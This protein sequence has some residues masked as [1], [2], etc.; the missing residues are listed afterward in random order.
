MRHLQ[1]A[2]EVLNTPPIVPTADRLL[3]YSMIGTR[4]VLPYLVAVKALH[5]R[6]GV[7]RVAILDDG[8]LTAN[9]KALLA[10]HC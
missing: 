10:H 2:R 3:L 1:T 5:A 9:D 7:G 4:V 6:L 8:T